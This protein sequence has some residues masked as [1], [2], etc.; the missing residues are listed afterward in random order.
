MCGSQ[1]K[2]AEA[3]EMF[4][5]ESGRM[6]GQASP[7]SWSLRFYLDRSTKKLADML[8]TADVSEDEVMAVAELYNCVMTVR[9]RIRQDDS[10]RFDAP[11]WETTDCS[12]LIPESQ[13]LDRGM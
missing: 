6:K 4:E 12:S 3:L 2:L 8:V 11:T 7:F 5:Q 9:H 10:W 1:D 13:V